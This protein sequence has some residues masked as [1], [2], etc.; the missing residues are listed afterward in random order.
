MIQI[1]LLRQGPRIIDPYISTIIRGGNSGFF[2]TLQ[3]DTS[4]NEQK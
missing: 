4:L 1:L 3:I 2:L